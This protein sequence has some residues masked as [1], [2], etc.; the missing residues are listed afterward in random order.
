MMYNLQR[1]CEIQIHAQAGGGE[2]LTIPRPILEGI[3]EQAKAAT[4]G[5]GGLLVWPGLLRKLDR[6]DSSFRD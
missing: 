3:G 2:L 5:L 1:S 4:K 6:L